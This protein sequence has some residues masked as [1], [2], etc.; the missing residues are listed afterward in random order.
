MLEK[1]WHRRRMALLAVLWVGMGT[2]IVSAQ[3]SVPASSAS[4]SFEVVAIKPSSGASQLVTWGVNQTGYAASNV[5]LARVILDAYIPPSKP[6]T[7]GLPL[8]RVRNAP[9]W[10]TS[11]LYDFTLKADEATIE[12][13]KG[14]NQAQQLNFES[15]A[16]KAMLLDRFRLSAHTVT[17]DALGYAI[18]VGKHG[19]KMRE[20]A[21][22]ERLPEG[23]MTFGG[24]YK[25]FFR[26]NGVAY[27]GITIGEYAELVGRG[28]VPVVDKTGLTARY[29]LELQK[30]NADDSGDGAPEPDVAHAYDWDAVGLEMKPIKLPVTSV[31]VDHV[32]RPTAN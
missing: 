5:P 15:P 13:T 14:M 12:A 2:G 19:V 3:T 32:E 24:S 7:T 25:V 22:D 6:T 17:A 23:G 1:G 30:L 8:D 21:A 18:A 29:D 20:M 9:S 10:V 11:T 4:P 28:P 26:K 27:V 31:V 16:L